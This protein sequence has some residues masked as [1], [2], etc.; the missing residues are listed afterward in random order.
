M[1][2][3]DQVQLVAELKALQQDFLN[4][5]PNQIPVSV[6]LFFYKKMSEI[7]KAHFDVD[8]RW[9]I[10]VHTREGKR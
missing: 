7:L 6:R 8:S 2:V 4:L 1:T 10:S 9:P 3:E 5:S